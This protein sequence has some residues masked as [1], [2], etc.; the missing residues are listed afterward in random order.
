MAEVNPFLC[1]YFY[2][3][4]QERTDTLL[5]WQTSGFF[6][7]SEIVLLAIFGG[8]LIFKTSF[9]AWGYSKLLLVT[10]SCVGRCWDRLDGCSWAQKVQPQDSLAFQGMSFWYDAGFLASSTSYGQ[11]CA[12]YL[13]TWNCVWMPVM[14]RSMYCCDS[15]LYNL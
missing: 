2:N 14:P 3:R 15:Y 12:Y 11:S 6:F 1:K 5:C 7:C 4:Q 10:M 8:R 13:G 9:S